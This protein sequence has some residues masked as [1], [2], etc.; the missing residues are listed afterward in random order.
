MMFPGL[1]AVNINH[2]LAFSGPVQ[3]S[4]DRS[5][6]PRFSSLQRSP[7]SGSAPAIISSSSFAGLQ[8]PSTSY[9]YYSMHA[10]TS[11]L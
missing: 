4:A 11:I 8:H 1:P 9:V 10:S 5:C 3:T 6:F 2:L 7:P